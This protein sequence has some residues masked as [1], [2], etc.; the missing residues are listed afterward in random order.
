MNAQG[1]NRYRFAGRSLDPVLR[2]I[3]VG[4]LVRDVEPKVFDLI[5]YLLRNRDRV[6]SKEE[7]QDKLWPKVVV[8]EASLSRSIMKARRVLD[9]DAHEPEVIRTVPRKGF[10]FVAN[11]REPVSSVFLADGLSDV[12]FTPSG[13][14]HIAW[15]TLGDG[16]DDIMFATGFV[17]HLDFRY[18]VREIAEFDTQLGA[19]KRLIVFDKRSVGLSDR[20]GRPPTLNDTVQDMKAVLDAA[21]SK[22][23]VIF[24]V[25]E[26]GPA[27]CKFAATYPERVSALI[28]FGTFAKGSQSEDYPHMPGQRLYK[29]WLDDLIANWGGPASLDYFAPTLKDDPNVQDGWAR[30]LRA[31]ASPGIIRGILEALADIDVR[32]CLSD[33]RCPTLVIHRD[34]DRMIW[35]AAGADLAARI[36]GARLVQLPGKDHWWFVGDTQVILDETAAFL[37]DADA[38]PAP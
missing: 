32:D 18:R 13:D 2:E 8:T 9:D 36:P 20:V 28:L 10:R 33:I 23:T 35:P 15:R 14:L 22:R 25:S 11:V 12:R 24:A 31:A 26:S 3:R 19:G 6:V 1:S 38:K 30:Y 29:A 27:A 4:D 5:E 16:P 34:G 17:S 37:R 21:G 7:L